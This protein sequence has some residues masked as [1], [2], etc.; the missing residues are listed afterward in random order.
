[1]VNP[2]RRDVVKIT[3]RFLSLAQKSGAGRF[4]QVELLGVQGPAVRALPIIARTIVK[5]VERIYE[6]RKITASDPVDHPLSMYG[7]HRMVDH[8]E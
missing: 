5:S 2:R 7:R 4:H 3:N 1:M 6:I 8:C